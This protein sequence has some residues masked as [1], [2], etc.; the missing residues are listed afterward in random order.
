MSY[1]I[2]KNSIINKSIKKL[3]YYDSFELVLPNPENYSVD[4]L[5]TKLFSTL[6]G[7]INTLMSIRDAIVG[8]LGLRTGK[9]KPVENVDK[10]VKY[11]AGSNA[12]YFT[13]LIRNENE[14]IL[15]GDD[16]HLYFRISV[17]KEDCENENIKIHLTTIVIYHN[18]FGKIYFFFVKPFH[19]LIVKAMLN[20]LKKA[21]TGK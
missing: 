2:P 7:W 21:E 16:K 14:I 1:T 17:L 12:G 4:Y 10:D 6:P 8:P 5:T 13:I 19:R 20:Q 18:I 3:D 15:S 9:D 11:E